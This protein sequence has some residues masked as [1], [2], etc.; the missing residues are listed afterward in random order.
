LPTLSIIAILELR[1][2]LTKK[3]REDFIGYKR[4]FPISTK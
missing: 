3:Y 4:I 1:S 2:I